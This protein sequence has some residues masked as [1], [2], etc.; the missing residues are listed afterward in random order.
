[1]GSSF[2]ESV[3]EYR[4]FLEKNGYPSHVIWVTPEDVLV[5]SGPVIYVR[6]PVSES[7]EKSVR[8]LFDLGISQER[9]V[10]FDTLCDGDG[11]T[12]SYAWVP[13]DGAEAEESLM[14]KGLKLSAKTGASR[15]PGRTVGSRLRWA[16]LQMK[17]RR[18]Q[19]MK[20]QMFR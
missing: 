3:A 5:S 6:V 16:Y 18:H 2:D 8:Q 10:L 11:L 4:N 20:E 19:R 13:R 15:V 12:F 9:G 17:N 14:P 1:M 7:N